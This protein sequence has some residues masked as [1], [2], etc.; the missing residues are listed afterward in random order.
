LLLDYLSCYKIVYLSGK[1]HLVGRTLL[2]E[3]IGSLRGQLQYLIIL[4]EGQL[5]QEDCP[6]AL[7]EEW[8][9]A[10]DKSWFPVGKI[11]VC[12]KNLY[13]VGRLALR[14]RIFPCWKTGLLKQI[15]LPAGLMALC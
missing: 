1:I 6:S 3:S 8:L 12:Q 5:K 2:F 14:R 13:H 15:R 4:A 11:A 7:P 9:S 10:E